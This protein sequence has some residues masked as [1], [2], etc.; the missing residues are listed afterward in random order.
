MSRPSFGFIFF[1]GICFVWASSVDGASTRARS[2]PVTVNPNAK[3]GLPNTMTGK[4]VVDWAKKDGKQYEYDVV[5]VPGLPTDPQEVNTMNTE[6]LLGYVCLP[7][8]SVPVANLIREYSFWELAQDGTKECVGHFVQ[9]FAGRDGQ[10]NMTVFDSSD[11]TTSRQL[12]YYQI[13]DEPSTL[14]IRYSCKK[15]NLQTGVCDTPKVIVD[16]RKQPD[17]LSAAEKASLDAKINAIL[18]PYCISTSTPDFEKST[19]KP[20]LGPCI[21]GPSATFN[22]LLVKLAALPDG[23]TCS[24]VKQAHAARQKENGGRHQ[25]PRA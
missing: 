22:A 1:V 17:Q 5:D 25:D 11:A 2:A 3:C 16:I 14:G 9:S 20:E 24:A 12:V 6:S 10:Q 23:S 15:P 18:A 21:P 7:G 19:F 8:S 13:F 4:L